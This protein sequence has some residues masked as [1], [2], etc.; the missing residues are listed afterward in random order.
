MFSFLTDI[1]KSCQYKDLVD[2]CI[3][4]YAVKHNRGGETRISVL[5]QRGK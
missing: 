4:N 2:G 3:V 5:N 1:G